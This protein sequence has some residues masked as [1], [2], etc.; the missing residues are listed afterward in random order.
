MSLK[1][2]LNHQNDYLTDSTNPNPKMKLVK[3]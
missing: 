2:P 3:M 1:S